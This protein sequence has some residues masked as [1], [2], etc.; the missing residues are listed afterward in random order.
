M[1]LVNRLKLLKNY[2][3]QRSYAS[4]GPVE[5]GIEV[6]NRCNLN[7][8]MCSRQEMTRP[9]GDISWDLFSKIVNQTSKAAEIYNLFGLGE[10]LLQP[11]LFKMIDY[12]QQKGVPV[13]LSTNATLLDD[14]NIKQLINHPPDFLLLA[15]DAQTAKT[16]QKIE[17]GGN[18]HQVRSNIQRYLKKKQE[19]DPPTFVVLLFIKQ[20]LN[21]A[22][23]F[24]FKKYWRN[25]GASVTYIKPVTQMINLKTKSSQP[26]RCLFP[27]RTLSVTW[28]GEVFPCCQDTNC[29]FNLGN[30]KDQSFEAIWNG[31]N[32][33]HLRAS[34]KNRQLEPLCLSCN[35]YRPSLPTTIAMSFLPE[36]TIK[37]AVPYLNP[38]QQ[39]FH[40]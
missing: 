28:Q 24:D 35:I 38:L 5:I 6:T 12:C 13:A 21:E 30:L 14:K 17:R 20:I 1:G 15:L 18:F 36:L 22:E 10:P 27:W 29:S 9:L 19:K 37:K 16:Y 23:V 8:I 32:W 7:C 31:P 2:L 11:L 3:A 40:F 34:F 39:L 4:H 33:Q 26:A 25:K